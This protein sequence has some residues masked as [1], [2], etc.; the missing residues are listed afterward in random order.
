MKPSWVALVGALWGLVPSI[1]LA[2]G[3]LVTFFTYDAEDAELPRGV[4]LILSSVPVTYFIAV[5]AAVLPVR[6]REY[7]QGI[8]GVASLAVAVILMSFEPPGEEFL[9][10]FVPAGVLLLIGSGVVG[11]T[12]RSFKTAKS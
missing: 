2:G 6:G 12:L 3:S 8:V 7:V 9:P 11:A 10:I 5:L 1:Y 4:F